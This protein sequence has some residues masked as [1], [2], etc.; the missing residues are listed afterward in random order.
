MSEIKNTIMAAIHLGKTGYAGVLEMVKIV[1]RRQYPDAIPMQKND[2]L[3]IPEPKPVEVIDCPNCY[4]GHQ[5]PC[6][7]CG[8]TGRVVNVPNTNVQPRES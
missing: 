7:W 1:D 6:Q 5:R 3:G 4:G 8:D 2:H